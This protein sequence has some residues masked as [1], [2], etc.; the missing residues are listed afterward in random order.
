MTARM[1]YHV[2][3]DQLEWQYIHGAQGLRWDTGNWFGGDINRLW[4]S[5][6]AKH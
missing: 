2:L 5:P 3:F 4:I 6:R 1:N